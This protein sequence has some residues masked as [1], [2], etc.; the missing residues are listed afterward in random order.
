MGN[1]SKLAE[2]RAKTD[3][4]LLLVIRVELERGLALANVAATKGSALYA[5]AERTYT[6][7]KSLL[8]TAYGVS[9]EERGRLE[10]QLRELRVTL[11]G[12]PPESFR[13]QTA[14]SI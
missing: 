4:E 5:R 13:Q 9:R 7:V 2:L 14:C 3:R 8:P 12:V 6:R 1:T 10:A 11:D